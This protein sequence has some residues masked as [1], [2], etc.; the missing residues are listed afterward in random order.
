MIN[1]SDDDPTRSCVAAE[2]L[3]AGAWDDARK[4]EIHAAI[5]AS[6]IEYGPQTWRALETTL[7]AYTGEW[8]AMHRNACEATYVHHQQSTRCFT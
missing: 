2:Q 5:E 8:L 3:L 6:G 1:D 7:D 4:Q